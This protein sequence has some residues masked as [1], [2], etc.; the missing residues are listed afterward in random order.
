MISPE[1]FVVPDPGETVPHDAV[2]VTWSPGTGL[3]EALSTVAVIVDVPPSRSSNPTL[4]L[5]GLASRATV[6]FDPRAD[7]AAWVITV[8][9]VNPSTSEVMV[10]VPAVAEAVYFDTSCPVELVRPLAGLRVPQD[11]GVLGTRVSTTGIP[12]SGR[13]EP[14]RVVVTV[15]TAELTAGRLA[16]L[17]VTVDVVDGTEKYPNRS[18][19]T[20]VVPPDPEPLST[21]T[22]PPEPRAAYTALGTMS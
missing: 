22:A 2:N 15:E 19:T 16:G 5:V 18:T 6:S 17:A 8:D 20:F 11:P 9:P 13:P 4:M 1:E 10:Q 21:S 12:A 3:P 7:P 14:S